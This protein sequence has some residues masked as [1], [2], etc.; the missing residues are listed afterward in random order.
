[1]LMYDKT[2]LKEVQHGSRGVRETS[3]YDRI[4]NNCEHC[5]VSFEDVQDVQVLRQFLPKYFGLARIHGKD[6]TYIQLENLLH[7]FRKPCVLDLKMGTQTYDEWASQ[8]KIDYELMKYPLQAEIGFR[9]T[10]SQV[11]DWSM[12]HYGML[13]LMFASNGFCRFG[14][15]RS[16]GLI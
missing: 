9:F 13:C 12:L 14:C 1:M 15:H 6:A 10:G 2:V 5:L 7:K 11:Q 3:F 16:N 4:F 8:E